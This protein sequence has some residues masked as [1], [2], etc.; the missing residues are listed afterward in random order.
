MPKRVFSNRLVT[1]LSV[2]LTLALVPLGA[3]AIY[4]EY[5]GWQRQRSDMETRLISRTS[6]AV[7]GQRALLGSA[8]DAARMLAPT[9]LEL[10]DD[11]V[12]CSEYL[13]EFI[14][15]AGL[16]AFAG[17][18]TAQGQMACV[19]TGEEQDFSESD[20]LA[21]MTEDPRP[22]FSFQPLGSATR[23]PVVLANFPVVEEGTFQ[24]IVSVSISQATFRL[25]S[26]PS[27]PDSGLIS[28]VLV[29]AKGHTLATSGA[30]DRTEILPDAEQTTRFIA[31]R[32]GIFIAPSVSTS[33]RVYTMVE[34]APRQLFAL[35]S[36][37]S[38]VTR[39]SLTPDL[40]RI[41]FPVLM[42]VASVGALILSL[43]YLV[44][45]HLRHVNVQ[46]RRF[47]LGNRA[48]FQRLPEDAPLELREIDSTF[49]KM[50]RLIRRDEIERETVLQE[51]TVLL[52]EVHHRV[53]NN[54]QLI[55]SILN[56]Q[57]RRL[58]DDQARTILRGVQTRVRALASIH[59]TLYEETNVSNL[60]ATMFLESIMRDTLALAP[61]Q[62]SRIQISTQLDTVT[63][64]PDKIVPV[65]L[66]FSE[67]LTN[68]LKYATT[69][70]Q[71][72]RASLSITLTADGPGIEL[73]L[74]NSCARPEDATTDSGLGR[75]LM[76]AFALQIGAE[77]DMGAVEDEQGSGWQIR[78]RL[79]G[80]HA[81]ADTPAPNA[82]ER[83]LS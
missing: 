41:A 48:D 75:E 23:Q 4:S 28:V 25:I 47:A 10:A 66:L 8:M 6:D 32:Q 81:S 22:S 56:L 72:D 76:T 21:Q 60:D 61:M 80:G 53:K 2:V 19:S 62:T 14:D 29:N 77:L 35:G 74:R 38:E 27:D 59:R 16:Y 64:S 45:R 70:A 7:Q 17:F 52:K 57:M 13:A 71:E 82:N 54:L 73:C 44:V 49:S 3:I 65:A 5:D 46:L 15:E 50:A 11:P 69:D 12:A 37:S 34:L 63:I 42:W 67:A 1:R 79:N 55:A 68:A 39:A 30:D 33:E 83:A 78:L 31:R 51:K 36:W 20:D 58:K 9:L 24:G 18:I 43:H 26:T 40:W